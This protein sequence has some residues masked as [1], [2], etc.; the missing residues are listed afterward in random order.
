MNNWQTRSHHKLSD[1]GFVVQLESFDEKWNVRA[2]NLSGHHF[3]TDILNCADS[4][5]TQFPK[6]YEP[7]LV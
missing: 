4:N 3:T 6:G 2:K 7:P 1:E 5:F